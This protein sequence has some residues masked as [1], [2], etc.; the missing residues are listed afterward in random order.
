MSYIA[1]VWTEL[2][3]ISLELWK[4]DKVSLLK[5]SNSRSV[6]IKGGLIVFKLYG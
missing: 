2:Y 5:M 3:M 6:H 1:F 4:G